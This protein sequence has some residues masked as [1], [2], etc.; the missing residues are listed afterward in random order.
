MS[1]PTPPNE[2]FHNGSPGSSSPQGRGASPV[3]PPN[4][5]LAGGRPNGSFPQTK[6]AS[7]V[8]GSNDDLKFKISDAKMPQP[9]S[10][11][12]PGVGMVPVNPFTG[13]G[14]MTRQSNQVPDRAPKSK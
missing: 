9:P 7:P 10:A 11:I 1:M 3:N 13:P 2:T 12:Q 14:G 6:Q 8:K 4:A 5:G